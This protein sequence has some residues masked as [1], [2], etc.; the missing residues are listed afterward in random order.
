MDLEYMLQITKMFFKYILTGDVMV[1]WSTT[2]LV[3]FALVA[4]MIV[5]KLWS[6]WHV[7]VKSQANRAGKLIFLGLISGLSLFG[8]LAKLW[9]GHQMAV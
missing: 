9:I 4:A 7:S 1:I 6:V 2:E 8:I 5:F 3:V